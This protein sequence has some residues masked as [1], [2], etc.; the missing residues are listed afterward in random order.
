MTDAVTLSVVIPCFNE[1][2]VL[3][4]LE[5]RLVPALDAL[6]VSWEVIFCD[7]G[8]RDR[9]PQL[10]EAMFQRDRRLRYLSFSRNFGHQAAI[11]AGLSEA[12]GEAVAIMDADLQD[13]P[14]LLAQCLAKWREG[15]EVVYAVR[16]TR[17][18]NIF[19]RAAYKLAYRTIRAMAA[20]SIPLDSGDFCLMDRKVVD[21]LVRMPER[22]IFL[23]G[24]RAWAGFRQVGIPYDR[25]ERKA[26]VTK[27]PFAKLLKLALDGVFSFSTVPLRIATWIGLST[28]V[29]AMG[30][31]VFIV[32]SRLTGWRLLGISAADVPGWSGMMV[33]VFFIG[34]VQ[35]LCLGVIGEYVG[36][37]YEE[38]KGR[39]RWVVR[40]VTRDP[41]G[42]RAGSP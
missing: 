14:E 26:G 23:R 3:P 24:M 38:A 7:D 5:K 31:I 12:R 41:N 2:E 18:E 30:A 40:P 22:N 42:A 36:R 37:I 39:P 25:D 16:A 19:M 13:P 33:A 17:K 9:T 28:V 15:Y 34:G 1:E 20:V 32:V 35:L 11:S 27:Y 6:G 8:S 10:L 4:L 29:L 21:V